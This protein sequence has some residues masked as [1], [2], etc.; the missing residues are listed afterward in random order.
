MVA[1]NRVCLLGGGP[2]YSTDCFASRNVLLLAWAL[3]SKGSGGSPCGFFRSCVRELF[4]R[5]EFR[6]ESLYRIVDMGRFDS[7]CVDAKREV[8]RTAGFCVDVV[9]A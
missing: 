5:G 4:L 7:A 1:Q 8:E 3:K 6:E 9:R 2:L